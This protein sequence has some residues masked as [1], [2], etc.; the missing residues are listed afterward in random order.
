MVEPS[1]LLDYSLF[2]ILSEGEQR[3]IAIADFLAETSLRTG[4]APVIFDDPVNSF[5]Y[6]RAT[7][8][9]KHRSSDQTK[10]GSSESM[11]IHTVL[12]WS[13]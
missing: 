12:K 8:L 1:S 10:M 13:L 4:T 11:R 6:R 9:R 2:D 7:K 5:D 3:V